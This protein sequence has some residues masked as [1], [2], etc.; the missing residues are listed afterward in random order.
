MSEKRRE[1]YDSAAEPC[2]TV[3]YLFERVVSDM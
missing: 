3:F 2:G 1:I